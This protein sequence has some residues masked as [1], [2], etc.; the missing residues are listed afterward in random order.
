MSKRNL[1]RHGRV[2]A[3]TSATPEQVWAVI[4]DVTRVGEWS[5]ECKESEWLPPATGAT[6]G[7]R[8]RGRNRTGR[9]GWARV[10][11][12]VTADP[13]REFGWRTVPSQL[14]RD[15][16]DWRITIEP[17]TEGTRIVQTY[18]VLR[19]NPVMERVIW[20]FMPAHRDRTP[21]LREDL[22]R[23]AKIAADA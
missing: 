3:T 12:V 23:L 15:S 19:L 10:N 18:D 13:P 6:V 17:V 11:E 5:H 1:N 7:A 16:T 14:Y 20:L 9:A 4:S 8:F 2:E 22:D 21:A